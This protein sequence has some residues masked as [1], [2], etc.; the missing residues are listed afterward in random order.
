MGER[1]ATTEETLEYTKM[2]KARV[3]IKILNITIENPTLH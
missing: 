3:N 2:T 1:G